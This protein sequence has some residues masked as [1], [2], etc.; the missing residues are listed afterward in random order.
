MMVR[1]H[2]TSTI[3]SHFPTRN[4]T[5]LSFFLSKTKLIPFILTMSSE[6]TTATVL[7][8]SAVGAFFWF[9]FAV[10]LNST[11]KYNLFHPDNKII[12]LAAAPVMTKLCMP[13]AMRMLDSKSSLEFYEKMTIAS[14]AATFIDGIVISFPSLRKICYG[15]DGDF[16][17]E[18]AWIIWGVGNFCTFGILAARSF[19]KKS[20]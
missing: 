3:Y 15:T 4:R 17:S 10:F 8:S 11:R 7:Q 12:M 9:G 20:N 5:Y 19:D 16:T 18:A 13:L 6:T 14:A 1:L 2:A